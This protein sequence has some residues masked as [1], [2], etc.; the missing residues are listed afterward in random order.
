MCAT[1]YHA[2]NELQKLDS[3]QAATRA[4]GARAPPPRSY[5]RTKEMLEILKELS[6]EGSSV[7]IKHF[8]IKPPMSLGC[9]LGAAAGLTISICSEQDD[10]DLC[11][12]EA[13]AT[14]PMKP[15]SKRCR[16]DSPESA[17]NCSASSNEHADVHSLMSLSTPFI[18]H[19]RA[20]LTESDFKSEEVVE[21][22]KS[23]TETAN[24]MTPDPHA[25]RITPDS[26]A[27]RIPCVAINSG[28]GCIG[29][30]GLFIRCCR[31]STP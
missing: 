28:C 30:S 15:A 20:G 21:Q 1:C 6:G 12:S 22:S 9:M 27:K 24:P 8:D 17:E 19:G 31:C 14:R 2:K 4:S 13:D 7:P 11:V 29:T 5:H 3:G 10:S 25:K 16:K 26:D 23:L 18:G